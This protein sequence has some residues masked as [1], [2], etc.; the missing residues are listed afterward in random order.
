MTNIE[1]NLLTTEEAAKEL[2]IS[3]KTLLRYVA[4]G[5]IAAY[6]YAKSYRFSREQLNVFL[7]KQIAEETVTPVSI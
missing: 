6:N 1:L 3:T 5:K 7:E 2:R 4:Q